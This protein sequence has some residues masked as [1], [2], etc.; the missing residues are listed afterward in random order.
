MWRS[1]A[2]AGFS[3]LAS[4]AITCTGTGAGGSPIASTADLPLDAWTPPTLPGQSV[5]RAAV[6]IDATLQGSSADPATAW[7]ADAGSGQRM[8]ALWPH[9]Y[10]A[11]FDAGLAV[12]DQS[13]AVVLHQGD[14]I[15]R[16]CFM[17]SA[18][19]YWLDPP[20]QR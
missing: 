3:L 12:I 7:L 19:E 17:G 8:Q 2:A 9:G 13:G 4:L 11:R 15:T 18:N 20:F 16:A 1:R 6:P 14:R 5:E 10:V